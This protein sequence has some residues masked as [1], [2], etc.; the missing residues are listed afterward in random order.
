[1][2]ISS[3]DWFKAGVARQRVGPISLGIAPRA[4]MILP[5]FGRSLNSSYPLNS[6]GPRG[7]TS[8]MFDRVCAFANKH[9]AKMRCALMAAPGRR[10]DTWAC[11]W[12]N[13]LQSIL[14]CEMTAHASS[15]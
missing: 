12:H 13:S 7:N 1:V 8:F 6:R 2:R 5:H 15:R 14:C 9:I 10:E 4:C 11:G 3:A